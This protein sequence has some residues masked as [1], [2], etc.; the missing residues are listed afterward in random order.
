MHAVRRQHPRIMSIPC[1][2]KLLR[3]IIF[4]Y[5]IVA[6]SHAL[7]ALPSQFFIGCVC[8]AH[9]RTLVCACLHR[10]GRFGAAGLLA[11]DIA[12][13]LRGDPILHGE[14]RGG[15]R[16]PPFL[17]KVDR[18]S[19]LWRDLATA[20]S[21]SGARVPCLLI[22]HPVLHASKMPT[23]RPNEN[24]LILSE[25]QGATGKYERKES[26]GVCVFITAGNNG[27]NRFSTVG[28]GFGVSSPR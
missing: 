2:S 11:P 3:S 28:N 20:L 9:A 4:Q 19:I 17:R 15:S 14:E 8:H 25:T 18:D 1:A 24:P 16:S 6:P 22:T 26:T 12:D 13:C 27:R 5:G 23:Q 21:S 10:G 7:H